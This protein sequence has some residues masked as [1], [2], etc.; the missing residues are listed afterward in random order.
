MKRRLLAF[1]LCV[2]LLCASALPALCAR[3]ITTPKTIPLLYGDD[4]PRTPEGVY[5]YML[6]CTDNR[7]T[8]HRDGSNIKFTDGLMLVTLDTRAKRVMLTSV[9]RDTLIQ[10]PKGMYVTVDGKV[11]P[12][13]HWGRINGVIT[14][15]WEV[16][17]KKRQKLPITALLDVLNAHLGLRIEKYVMIDFL[18]V[19]NIID[20][21]GGV[22]ITVTDGESIYLKSKDEYKTTWT[23]PVLNG[24]G[25]YHFKGHAALIYMRTRSNISVNHENQDL[26]RTTRARSVVSTLAKQVSGVTYDELFTLV[27]TVVKNI[28]CTNMTTNELVQAAERAYSLRACDIEQFRIPMNGT[29]EEV[30]YAGMQVQQ[31]DFVTN[32][33]ALHEFLFNSFYVVDDEAF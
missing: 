22:D 8:A 33:N 3:V 6:I 1:S 27:D 9:T 16:L 24:A 21:L 28:V 7:D 15:E 11:S 20:Q 5:H 31:V 32:R 12:D 29:Y 18:S 13:T 26:R 23:T 19:E 14:T 25:T 10:M 30:E 2:F 17:L 4:V